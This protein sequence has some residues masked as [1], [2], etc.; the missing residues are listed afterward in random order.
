MFTNKIN[1]QSQMLSDVFLVV[2]NSFAYFCFW[3]F[4][5][6]I[7]KLYN[8]LHSHLWLEFLKNKLQISEI[9]FKIIIKKTKI[10][11]RGLEKTIFKKVMET[12]HPFIS[13]CYLFSTYWINKLFNQNLLFHFFTII[14]N[15]HRLVL[16]FDGCFAWLKPSAGKVSSESSD[17]DGGFNALLLVCGISTNFSISG[18]D[19]VVKCLCF[20]NN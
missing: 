18:M 8:I 2:F 3:Y 11:R 4:L 5:N 7:L 13:K 15:N 9:K 1:T 16:A 17:S 6:T 20:S 19:Y 10:N 12:T 14:F